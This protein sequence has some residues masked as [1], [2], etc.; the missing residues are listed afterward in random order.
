M[1]LTPSS[2]ARRSTVRDRLRS[3]VVPLPNGTLP[4]SRI[5]PKP[6]RLTVRSPS[7]HVPAAAASRAGELTGPAY[8][9]LLTA[10]L[11]RRAVARRCVRPQD[12]APV[13]T[14]GFGGSVG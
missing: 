3:L 12:L 2:T 14:A 7:R 13:G 5:A 1:W 9:G 8:G 10:A 6:S 4:V 11:L